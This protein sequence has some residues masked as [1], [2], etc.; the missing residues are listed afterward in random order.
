MNLA[1]R[2]FWK[3]QKGV[4]CKSLKLIKNF[5]LLKG[6]EGAGYTYFSSMPP[7]TLVLYEKD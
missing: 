2:W 3:F 6:N 1:P 5:W 4:L 7:H